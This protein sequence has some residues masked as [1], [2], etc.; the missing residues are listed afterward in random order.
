MMCLSYI[1][2]KFQYKAKH[3]N[4]YHLHT[5]CRMLP[6]T[7]R[8]LF[9]WNMNSWLRREALRATVKSSRQSLRG[10]KILG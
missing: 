5:G 2:G 9:V 1:D 7:E 10:R 3:E 6:Y 8:Y 4:R